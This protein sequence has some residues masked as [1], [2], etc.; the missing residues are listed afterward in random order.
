MAGRRCR[1]RTFVRTLDAAIPRQAALLA[2]R[3]ACLRGSG[4]TAFDRIVPKHAEH[5]ALAS[6]YAH[7][8]A[9]LRRLVDRYV[10]ETCIALSEG[11]KVPGWVETEL[12]QLPDVMELADRKA[13]QY[14]A[15]IVSTLEAAILERSVGKTFDAVVIEVDRDGTQDRSSSATRQSPGA[16][17]GPTC[18]SARR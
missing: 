10:G 14:E 11:R 5:A 16:A 9:P 1:I 6:T 3:R 12:P 2:R 18:R 8:T 17:T 7:T 13:G 15:G 4:Y